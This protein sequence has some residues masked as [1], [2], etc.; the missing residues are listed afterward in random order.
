MFFKKLIRSNPDTV[1][2][3]SE[4]KREIFHIRRVAGCTTLIVEMSIHRFKEEWRETFTGFATED[5]AIG[6]VRDLI[7]P[8]FI[9][10]V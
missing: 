9:K 8:C 2:I 6:F 4:D 10:E 5:E 1:D 3:I 7:N